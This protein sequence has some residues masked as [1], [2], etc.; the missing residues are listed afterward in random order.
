L[1][2]SNAAVLTAGPDIIIRVDDLKRKVW[3]GEPLA[4]LVNFLVASGVRTPPVAEYLT[5]ET[6][7][8]F[9]FSFYVRMDDDGSVNEENKLFRFGQTL[10]DF[11]SCPKDELANLGSNHITIDHVAGMFERLNSASDSGLWKQTSLTEEELYFLSEKIEDLHTQIYSSS[12]WRNFPS[13]ILHGDAHVG[14]SIIHK[15]DVWLIDFEYVSIGP[16][17]LDHLH[18]LMAD[19]VF[20]TTDYHIFADGYGQNFS[21]EVDTEPWIQLVAIPYIIWTASAGL[22]SDSH[23]QEATRRMIW[24]KEGVDSSLIWKSGF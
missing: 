14:N 17:F 22:R 15:K 2:F 1:R 8:D 20:G 19:A 13:V 18:V 9:C 24:L 7:E 21:K 5:P 11:H 12:E 16:A 23:R 3:L 6:K 10:T 4:Q